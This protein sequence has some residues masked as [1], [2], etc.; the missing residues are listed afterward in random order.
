M[1][2]AKRKAI[3]AGNWT[4]LCISC[5]CLIFFDMNRCIYIILY[6]TFT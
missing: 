4:K 1:D 5:L 3:I 6:K 2:K